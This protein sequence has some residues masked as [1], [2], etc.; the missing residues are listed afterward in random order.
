MEWPAS[1]ESQA[2]YYAFESSVLQAALALKKAYYELHFLEGKIGVNQQTLSLVNDVEKLA[3]SQ[4][5]AGKVTLQDVLRAQM[6]QDR[7]TSE[8]ENLE[9]SRNPALTQLKSALGL[10]WKDA[11]PP[12]PR[13]FAS[14]PLHLD[15][16]QFMASALARNPRLRA[17]EAEVQGADA[18]LPHIGELFGRDHTTVLHA[19]TATERR[20]KDD[21]S[22]QAVV[23]ALEQELR[24]PANT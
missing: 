12:V 6:E 21:V 19:V 8:I 24:A 23:S 5:E 7:L 11:A 9:D 17:M 15:S 10:K 3:R 4:N 14:T 16:S 13:R 2:K 18:S 1:A 20:L 22:L